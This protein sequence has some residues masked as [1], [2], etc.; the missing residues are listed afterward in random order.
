V[1]VGVGDVDA[2]GHR[3]PRYL[4]EE[5]PWLAFRD[6]DNPCGFV[7]FDVDP[8]PADGPTTMTGRYL[9]VRG[10]FGDTEVVDRFTL[11]RPRRG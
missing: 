8:G 5:A 6:L 1:L 7:V 3:A 11:T 10:P 4:E 2:T 9:A